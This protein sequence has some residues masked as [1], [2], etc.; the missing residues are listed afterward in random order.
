MEKGPSP[1]LYVV[2][3]QIG[4]YEKCHK[5]GRSF[6]FNVRSLAHNVWTKVVE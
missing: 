3:T 2:I 1:S 4:R 6:D 5:T